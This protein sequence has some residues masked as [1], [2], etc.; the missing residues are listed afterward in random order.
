[1]GGPTIAW[2]YW[3][4]P[5]IDPNDLDDDFD[6]DDLSKW[7]HEHDSIIYLPGVDPDDGFIII[8]LYGT[9]MS[10]T[11]GGDEPLVIPEITQEKKDMYIRLVTELGL[12]LE[13][14]GWHLVATCVED[15][16]G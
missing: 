16:G 6:E 1:M 8:A 3:G 4:L 15:W 10:S 11:D 2:L 5:P 13:N 7:E 14:L 12:K 9:Q